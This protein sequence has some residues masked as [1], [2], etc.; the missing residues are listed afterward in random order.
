[1]NFVMAAVCQDL[2]TEEEKAFVASWRYVS[3]WDNSEI[4]YCQRQW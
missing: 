2:L 3:Y 1:M 4:G